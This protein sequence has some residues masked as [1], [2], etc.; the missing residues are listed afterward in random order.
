[1]TGDTN[2]TTDCDE[3][4]SDGSSGTP[5]TASFTVATDG[6]ADGD[7]TASPVWSGDT[8]SYSVLDAASL[9]GDGSNSNIGTGANENTNTL[10]S[11]ASTGEAAVTTPSSQAYGVWEFSVATGDN[12][13]TSDVNNFAIILT[14]DTD[15]ETKLKIGGSM[16]FN[17]YYIKLK[18]DAAADKFVLMKQEGT[19]ETEILD[20]N[21]PLAA[22]AN[23]GYTM[24]V[25]R[26]TGGDWEIFA[27]QGFDNTDATTSRGTARDN[28][29]TTSGYFAVST[30]ITTGSAARRL[31]FDN[32]MLGAGTEVGFSATSATVVE[33]DG[34][35]TYDLTVNISDVDDACETTADVVLVSGS[36]ARI[37]SYT[38]QSLTW[39]ANDAV[40]KT[41]TLTVSTNTTCEL[42]ETLVF[43]LQNISGGCS[44]A[45]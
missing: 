3:T 40:S 8:G 35:Q 17:G 18:N 13:N 1:A 2:T 24:K 42:D 45:N 29:V 21:Y 11:N 4:D 31:Y 23:L 22:N 39:A 33:T 43:E 44:A 15:D 10:V 32:F 12:W 38:T 14:S 20:L 34:A 30:N 5:I 6:F 25:V 26:T 19:T 28:D 36:A 7:F 16:D 37:N 9:S 27:D 41:V